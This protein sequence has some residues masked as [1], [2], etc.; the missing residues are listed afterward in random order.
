MSAMRKTILLADDSITIRKV[1]ELTFADTDIHVEAVGTGRE[2]LERLDLLR[3]DLVLAD[4]VMPE[5]TGYEVCRAV[6]GSGRPVP[7]L[8]LAGTFEPF[9]LERARDAGADGHL[10]KPFESRTLVDC[11]VSLLADA[12]RRAAATRAPSGAP[13]VLDEVW[14]DDDAPASAVRWPAPAQPEALEGLLDE[15]E[16]GRPAAATHEIATPPGGPA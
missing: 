14:G 11:V 15:A 10:T 13:D 8:L 5:P 12:E 1:V 16:A 6:K 7:V 9:D 3:P 4:V 2:A